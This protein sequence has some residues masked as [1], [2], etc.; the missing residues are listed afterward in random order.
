MGNVTNFWSPDAEE[1]HA[2]P[3]QIKR[4]ESA[5]QVN[6]DPMQ[7]DLET[8]TCAIKDYVVSL[9]SC[10]CKDASLRR[11]PCKHMYRLAHEL[12]VFDLG[13]VNVD[14]TPPQT[15]LKSAKDP[16]KAPYYNGFTWAVPK[17]FQEALEF[18]HFMQGDILY[19]NASA[20]SCKWSEAAA[21]FRYSIQVK[22]PSRGTSVGKFED[23]WNHTVCVVLTDH[24][25]MPAEFPEQIWTTQ[26]RL[27]TLLQ[28][29]DISI[30]NKDSFAPLPPL[31][32]HALLKA[33]TVS[34]FKIKAES[35]VAQI[36]KNGTNLSCFM[37]P[38][39][40]SVALSRLKFLWIK[41]AFPSDRTFLRFPTPTNLQVDAYQRF[42]PTLRIACF[43]FA[44]YEKHAV[45]K[46]LKDV[47]YKPDQTKTSN[48]DRFRLNAH[49]VFIQHMSK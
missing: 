42:S 32:S 34:S 22:A 33:M 11:L 47:L 31:R 8:S 30:I 43:L 49:G 25:K 10:T 48:A 21:N 13:A 28:T 46:I 44:G 20:Y 39:D 37:M 14:G 29:G 40:S 19:D 27:Y 3:E 41:S 4:Q 38:Y 45:L 7:I 36:C 17:A 2:D 12:G 23:N 16:A 35:Y 6:L 18:C 9:D 24:R 5:M 15:I 26:G 1:L